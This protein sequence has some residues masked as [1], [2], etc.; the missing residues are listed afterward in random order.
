VVTILFSSA[1]RRVELIRC[2]QQSA[3]DLGL[4]LRTLVTDANAPMCAASHAADQSFTVPLCRDPKFIPELLRLCA[5]YKVELLVPTIDPELELLAAHREDFTRIGTRLVLSNLDLIRIAR[6][7]AETVKFV[8]A[9]GIRA[10]RTAL[11]VDAL[12]ERAH[13]NFPLVL[14][15]IDGSSSIG[16]H[17]VKSL[18]AVEVLGLRPEKYVAQEYWPGKE[19]TVNLFFAEERLRCAI[20]YRRLQVRSG[21]VSKGMTQR[22]PAIMQLAEALGAAM[23]GRAYGPICA[24]AIVNDANEAALIEINARFGGGYPLAHKAGAEFSRWLLELHLG[25][26][27]SA[28]N[29]WKENLAML[30]YDAAVFLPNNA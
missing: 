5:D 9:A 1:G 3:A 21:E 25:R 12:Q 7:K 24:Q 15:E 13:W 23:A 28:N 27:C 16:V 8:T 17:H 29:D 19:Y 30:R 2:F 6:H 14:K 18:A 10:P 22:V 20:P 26:P 4:Q 11:L